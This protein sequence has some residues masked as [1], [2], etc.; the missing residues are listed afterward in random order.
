MDNNGTINPNE[1]PAP[2][3]TPTPTPV[4]PSPQPTGQPLPPQPLDPATASAPAS[5]NESKKKL[6]L[7]IG[8]VVGAIAIIAIII[9]LLVVFLNG[10]T[11]TVSCTQKETMMGLEIEAK[12]NVKVANGKI[13]G[14]DVEATIN[15]NNLS[16]LYASHEQELVDSILESYQK[17]C[18][19]GCKTDHEY[20][21]GDHLKITA[22]YDETGVKELVY[23]YGIENKSAQEIADK[24]QESLERSGNTTCKQN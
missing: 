24:I 6:Y 23:S 11:K 4:Q 2:S 17:Q 18:E 10:G 13:L 15:L 5:S 22:E 8:C 3:P 1:A 20:V 7:I 21:E 9:V 12:T 14:G 19:E 16:S